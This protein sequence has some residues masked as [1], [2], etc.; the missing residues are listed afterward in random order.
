MLSNFKSIVEN[1][2]K[3]KDKVD[4]YNWE[5]KTEYIEKDL[6]DGKIDLA[7]AMKTLKEDV[8]KFDLGSDDYEKIEKETGYNVK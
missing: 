5:K 7:K 2:V 8:F 6:D 4:A 1:V 3:A